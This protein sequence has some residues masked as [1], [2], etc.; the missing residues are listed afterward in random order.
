MDCDQYYN[1]W[2]ATSLQSTVWWSS[3]VQPPCNNNTNNRNKSN[4]S[5]YIDH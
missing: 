3:P 4:R 1:S 2:N 5:V